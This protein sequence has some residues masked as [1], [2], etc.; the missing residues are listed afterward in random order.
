MPNQENEPQATILCV[1]DERS[2]LKSL[3]RLFVGKP[4]QVKLADSGQAALKIME[5]QQVQVIISDMR[6]PQM[7]GA[8][9]LSEAAK[10]Q[11]NSYRILMTGYADLAS[12]VA[13]INIG[14]IHRYV[15]KPWDN[16]EL[17]ELVEDGL[18]YF[19]LLMA[20]K[21][22]TAKVARQNTQLK[23]LNQNLE[24]V[25]DQRTKQL[26]RTINQV[27]TL[28]ADRETENSAILEVL[29][30]IISI[31]PQLSGD[32]ARHVSHTAA[33]LARMA[34]LDQERCHVIGQ[35]GLYCELG[36]LS[37]PT[38]MLEK[39]VHKI[40]GA[41]LN[42]Y[43][44]HPQMA[45]DMLRPAV[46]LQAMSDIIAY[47]YEKYNGSGTPKQLSGKTI[48]VGSR[49]L[50]VARDFWA[51]V[52]QQLNPKEMS[53]EEAY[54]FL[55]RQQGVVYDPDI[56][57]LLGMMLAN[58]SKVAEPEMNNEGRPLDQVAIGMKLKRNLYNSRQ[59]LMLPK[60]HVI[61]QES[62]DHLRQ[63]LLSHR[64]IL[65]LDVE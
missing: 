62:I 55:K 49:I 54:E 58:T 22:L 18:S 57:K 45:E 30:N 3:Q 16:A 17:I 38:Q 32:Y 52:F 9:F 4:Y 35:A 64:E 7:S 37:F 65:R 23:E 21:Q 28:L 19:R 6:M 31:N 41:E 56:I 11:P 47:Q 59:M 40:A 50:A 39:P 43:L 2:I 20:N 36:K 5:E 60:G 8:Q 48:P 1:D 12:T 10:M 51:L 26:I 53:H 42:S 34:K 14:K 24:A 15:Q 46:H 63:Y 25:V 44:T 13:A 61:T 29:Y 33:E 27:K